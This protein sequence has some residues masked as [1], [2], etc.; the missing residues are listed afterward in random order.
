[1]LFPGATLSLPVGRMR[2]VAM[3]DTL[4]V[5]D[6][7]V[8]GSQ[9]GKVRALL[10]DRGDAA[11]LAP[12]SF[13]VEVL[14]FSGAPEAGDRVAVVENEARAREITEYRERQKREKIAARGG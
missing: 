1:M 12:P 4:H 14:G 8:A 3:L 6:L 10:D 11:A 9:W 5:G 13:P 2:S 7:I